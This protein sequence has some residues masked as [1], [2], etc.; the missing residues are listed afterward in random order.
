MSFYLNPDVSSAHVLLFYRNFQAHRPQYCH[1][2]LGVNALHTAKVLRRAKVKCDVYGVYE[3]HHIREKL[4]ANSTVTH[5]IIEAPWISSGEMAKLLF[6]FPDVHFVVRAHSQIGF[7][8][9]EPGAIKIL[10]DLLDLQDSMLNLSVSAN[11]SKLCEFLEKTYKSRC[12]YLPNLYDLERSHRKTDI[13]HGT[14]QML[15]IGSFGAMRIMKNHTTAAAA[16][17]QIAERRRSDLEFWVSVNREEHGKGVLQSLRNMFSGLHWAKLVENPWED[18]T[19]FRKTV[20]H[21][22]LCLQVSYSETFNIVTADAAAE[23]VPSVT[24]SAI[25][26]TP[27]H[28]HA[29]P[30][31]VAEIA[32]TGMSLLS[33]PGAGDDGLKALIKYNKFG[34]R[35]WL[36]WL[37]CQPSEIISTD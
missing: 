3:P 6:E 15:R 5:A 25:E 7:L 30:D 16:A 4:L 22:D 1:I 26:W 31:S 33:D 19:K 18:W 12:L 29:D 32:R 10:R 23:C 20:G 2:G 8:Q 34:T 24:S 21:M 14:R 17:L 27:C 11:S 13:D 36:H 37:S 9:V 28:W 35:V